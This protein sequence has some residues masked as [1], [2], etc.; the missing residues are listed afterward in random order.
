MVRG[1]RMC[2]VATKQRQGRWPRATT[3]GIAS[4]ADVLCGSSRFVG[5]ERVTNLWFIPKSTGS[6]SSIEYT[7]EYTTPHRC[8]LL[9][10]SSPIE[11]LIAL[12]PPVWRRVNHSKSYPV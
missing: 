6:P 9:C 1:F 12:G 7:P 8:M 2:R 5:E 3:I 10:L 4:Y 11:C